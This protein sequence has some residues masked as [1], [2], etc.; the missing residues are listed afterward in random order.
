MNEFLKEL[1]AENEKLGFDELNKKLQ[2]KGFKLADLS[3]GN[4]VDK[5]K[6]DDDIGSLNKKFNDLDSRTACVEEAV[7]HYP[8]YREQ[9]LQIQNQLKQ[10]DKNILEVCDAIKNLGEKL[11]SRL[12]DLEKRERNS[13]RLK[14][15]DEYRLYTNANK[16]PRAA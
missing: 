16:N 9:S 15:L 4:Y 10:S 5:K 2:E 3:K 1:F 11:N 6:Y 8:E 13:L 14:I 7:S 12:E